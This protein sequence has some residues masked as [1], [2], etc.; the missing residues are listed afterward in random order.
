M[1]GWTQNAYAY[2]YLKE[3]NV[4]AMD[5]SMIPINL[6]SSHERFQVKHRSQAKLVN[7]I[8]FFEQ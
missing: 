2:T 1:M 4:Q 8:N 3:K 6:G 7:S 5:I